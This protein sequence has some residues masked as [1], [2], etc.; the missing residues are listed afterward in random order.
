M[1]L[2]L[3][4]S[5]PAAKPT[6]DSDITL[7]TVV[8]ELPDRGGFVVDIIANGTGLTPTPLT[9]TAS[10]QKDSDAIAGIFL[11]VNVGDAVSGTGIAT[12][13]KVLEVNADNLKLSKAATA[14]GTG[15]SLTFTSPPGVKLC[16][17]PIAINQANDPTLGTVLELAVK[18]VNSLGEK[19][20][21]A[22]QLTLDTELSFNRI[23]RN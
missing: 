19:V 12:A 11:G 14:D 20:L 3:T 15:V 22:S 10:T 5:R 7:S 13:T 23:P 16:S 17:L 2:N 4:T 9:V 1:P 21:G 18:M 6:V 8:S